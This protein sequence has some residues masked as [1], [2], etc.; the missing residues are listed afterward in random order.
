MEGRSDTN[1]KRSQPTQDRADPQRSGFPNGRRVDIFTFAVSHLSLMALL[2]FSRVGGIAAALVAA[3]P[4]LAQNPALTARPSLVS[5]VVAG[6]GGA[7]AAFATREGALYY[8]PAHLTRAAGLKPS[9]RLDL[10]QIGLTPATVWSQYEFYKDDLEPAIDEDINELP[11]AERERLFEEAIRN[12]RDRTYADI[13]GGVSALWRVGPVAAG[14]GLH[15][16]AL[17]RYRTPASGGNLPLVQASANVDLIATASGALDLSN[18]GL[19]G[20]S[21]GLSGRVVHRM[22]TAKDKPLDAF[23]EDEGVFEY[24]AT[25]VFFDI[26]ATYDVPVAL[27][28]RLVVGAAGYDVISSGFDYTYGERGFLGAPTGDED[29]DQIDADLAVVERDFAVSPSYRIGVAYVAPSFFGVFRETGVSLDYV[30]YS[31][32]LVADRSAPLGL[33]LGAQAQ[34]LRMVALRVGLAEGYPTAGVGLGLGPIRLDYA[35][36]GQEDG[37]TAGQAPV[38]MHRLNLALSL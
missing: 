31:D 15:A 10:P 8:N 22:V 16:R 26:G 2:S 5:P 34:V 19:D 28:G 29:P 32:P 24:S 9:I 12:G 33:H 6:M 37:R 38:W 17:G 20:A 4:A 1:E 14:A 11:P 25:G 3:V 18:F 21:V 13:G 23:S 36:H 30:G 27:P 7:A 35:V